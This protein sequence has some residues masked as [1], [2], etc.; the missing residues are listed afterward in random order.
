[1]T[2]T[3]FSIAEGDTE[4]GHIC[5]SPGTNFTTYLPDGGSLSSIK[6]FAIDGNRISK[7]FSQEMEYFKIDFTSHSYVRVWVEDNKGRTL[8]VS[9]VLLFELYAT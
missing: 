9:G 1:M 2:L 3:G 7:S 8:D 6:T 5:I 4:F